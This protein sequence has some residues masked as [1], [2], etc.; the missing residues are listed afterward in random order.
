VLCLNLMDEAERH[1]VKV[2]DRQLARDLGVPVVPASARF[3]RGLPELLAA[4]EQ[5]AQ[6]PVT[7][8]VHRLSDEPP[9]IRSALGELTARLRAAYPDLPNARWIAMRLLGGDDRVASALRRGELAG[10]ADRA[11]GAREG[12][13]AEAKEEA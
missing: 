8:R 13:F 6:A 9:A 10:L 4:I 3:G 12:L 5:V 7:G 1:G 11:R 2:D